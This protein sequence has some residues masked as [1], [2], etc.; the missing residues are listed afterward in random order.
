[1]FVGILWVLN[2]AFLKFRIL[3]ILN[4]HP[5]MGQFMRNVKYAQLSSWPR[6]LN[7][8]LCVWAVNDLARLR[9]AVAYTVKP[10]QNGHSQKDRKLVS[11]TNYCLM[12]V[13]SIAE[14]SKGSILQYFWPSLSYHLS[15][16]SLFCPFWVAVLHTFYCII[17]E[18]VLLSV[19]EVCCKINTNYEVSKSFP[20][21]FI[22]IIK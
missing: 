17:G 4:F 10:V 22:M 2:F 8:D 5:C 20:R 18:Y 15:L 19:S 12:Q 3:E 13:K 7:F 14:C 11:K 16:R 21:T 1:M 9:Y 6:R